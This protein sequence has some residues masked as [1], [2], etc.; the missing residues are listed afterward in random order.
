M[1]GAGCWGGVPPNATVGAAPI[2]EA[3]SCGTVGV[4]I[5]D[6]SKVGWVY[7]TI[8]SQ[9]VNPM[10]LAISCIHVVALTGYF[11]QATFDGWSHHSIVTTGRVLWD[12][13]DL[14]HT[15]GIE[16]RNMFS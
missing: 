13:D 1:L 4:M 10:K 15:S 11:A 9:T 12:N 2:L 16:T 3:N 8:I 6:A 14:Y 7:Q 5:V